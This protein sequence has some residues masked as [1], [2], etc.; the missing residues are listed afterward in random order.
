MMGTTLS[1]PERPLFSYHVDLER[2]V[3]P[4]HPLRQLHA[5]LE[6]AF[7]IPAVKG[8]YGRSGNVSLDPRVI[9]KMMLLLFYYNIPSE[10]ELMA[11]IGERLDLLW[12]L[13]FDL[14]TPIPDHSVLSK[15]RARWGDEVFQQLFSRT[16]RQC[17]EA[18]L[19]DGRLLHLDST[20]VKANASKNSILQTSPEMVEALRQAYQEQAGKLEVL[21]PCQPEATAPSPQPRVL[22]RAAPTLAEA[23][24]GI[25]QEPPEAAQ[26]KPGGKK[27]PVNQTHISLTDPQA[28]NS[29]LQERR[30]RLDLQRAPRSR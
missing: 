25:A 29:P 15:A 13:G 4:D 27:L 23:R 24:S 18:G 28:P 16:V 26:D 3:R 10:R 9:L 14:E 20:I 6:L 5:A 30:H 7:V 1:H 17:V 11:Q 12:F 2:R 19:V 8:L 21:A 22:A